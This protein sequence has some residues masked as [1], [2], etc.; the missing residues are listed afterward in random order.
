MA[1]TLPGFGENV[2][3]DG[4]SSSGWKDTDSYSFSASQQPDSN[5]NLPEASTIT[6]QW[7]QANQ[8]DT[9]QGQNWF[10]DSFSNLEDGDTTET[11]IFGDLW[12]WV[13]SEQGSSVMGGAVDGAIGVWLA[14]KAEDIN[15]SKASK[16]AEL[17]DARVKKHNRSINAPTTMNLRRFKK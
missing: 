15:S 7:A 2:N 11:D 6:D 3:L 13:L 10:V 14:D 17:Y 1:F 12:D 9:L 16:S 4:S 5:V 8:Q